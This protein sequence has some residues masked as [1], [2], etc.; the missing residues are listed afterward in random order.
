MAGA[1]LRLYHLRTAL[2]CYLAERF[3]FQRRTTRRG[4]ISENGSCYWEALNK[5]HGGKRAI[6]VDRVISREEDADLEAENWSALLYLCRHC[7]SAHQEDNGRCQHCGMQ[8]N[9]IRLYAVRS[10]P[11]SEGYLSS[12]I[13]C[14]AKGRRMGRRYREPMR[15]VRAITVSDV[16]V[17]TQ[18]M[19]PC[20]KTTAAVICG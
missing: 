2:F 7:G 1:G 15:E 12:C 6:L 3:Y 8:T 9:L 18:D 19:V 17:L 13:S 20:R 14:T 16:H 5:D 10:N 11:K 4:Q